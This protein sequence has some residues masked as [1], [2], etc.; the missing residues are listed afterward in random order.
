[1][2]EIRDATPPP[3]EWTD[4]FLA[5]LAARDA[6]IE[7]LQAKISEDRQTRW[8]LRSRLDAVLAVLD[9]LKV[10]NPAALELCPYKIGPRF[11]DTART[12]G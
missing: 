1:M 6:E 2:T 3:G 7:A 12:P 10:N 5:Q 8:A 9:W 11:G 4:Y